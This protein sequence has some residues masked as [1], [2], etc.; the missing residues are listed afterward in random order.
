MRVKV[1]AVIWHTDRLVVAEERRRGRRHLTLPGGRIKER[2]SL[3]EGLERE[4][5]EE[6]RLVV[7]ANRLL[8]VAEAVR[9]Y[10]R[11]EIN[12]IFLANVLEVPTG[13][14]L[15]LVDL[16]VAPRPD[17]L[18]PILDEIANDAA[19]GWPDGARWLGNVWTTRQPG[20]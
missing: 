9:S 11:Q 16:D 17:V 5:R 19:R 12:V 20:A 7:R 15:R 4:V 13:A 6:T 14:Q 1:R 18:P 8:Y 10:V 3:T 2:E